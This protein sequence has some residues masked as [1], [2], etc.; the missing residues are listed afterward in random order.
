MKLATNCRHRSFHEVTDSWVRFMS[1]GSIITR[2]DV[3]PKLVRPDHIALLA[4]E[5]EAPRVVDELP[6]NLDVLASIADVVDGTVMIFS[7]VLEGDACIPERV[8]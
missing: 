3:R 6:G 4:S 1:Q 2:A 5:S 8:G 7:A